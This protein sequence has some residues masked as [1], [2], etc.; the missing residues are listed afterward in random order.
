MQTE[1]GPRQ[2]SALNRG[3]GRVM[4]RRAGERNLNQS[5]LA[6]KAQVVTSQVNHWW[7]DDRPMTVESL[8]TISLALGVDPSAFLTEARIEAEGIKVEDALRTR[9]KTP[10]EEPPPEPD[11]PSA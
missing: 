5:E 1:K 3:I 10:D 9:S 6:R 8:V 2:L 7:N 11:Q 4:R